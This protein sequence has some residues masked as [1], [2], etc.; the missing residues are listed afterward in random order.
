MKHK[1]DRLATCCLNNC[2]EPAVYFL[3]FNPDLDDFDFYPMCRK[4]SGETVISGLNGLEVHRIIEIDKSQHYT[5]S[6]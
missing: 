1:K 3:W 4:H 5:L 2:L 6:R